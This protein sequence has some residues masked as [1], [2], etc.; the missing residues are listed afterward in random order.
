MYSVILVLEGPML[1]KISENWI[2]DSMLLL[3]HLD[4]FLVRIII[5]NLTPEMNLFG[6]SFY[7]VTMFILLALHRY[8][9]P[10]KFENACN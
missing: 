2:M 8:D 6:L 4:V 10:Q 9:P 7:I 3:G 1:G 5:I